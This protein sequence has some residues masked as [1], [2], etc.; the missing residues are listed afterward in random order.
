MSNEQPKNSLH[1]RVT[2]AGGEMVDYVKQLIKDG[3]VRRLI[4]RKPSGDTLIEVPLTA[5]VA[6]G[7]ALTLFTPVL[8]AIGAMAGLLAK[9]EIDIERIDEPTPDERII[10][11]EDR[12]R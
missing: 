6:V 12:D 9:F 1:E 7:G 10:E 5:G 2:V 8:A 3:N 11:P 4:I